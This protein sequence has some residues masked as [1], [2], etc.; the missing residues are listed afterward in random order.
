MKIHFGHCIGCDQPIRPP[1]RS[2]TVAVATGD[3]N[4]I[5][6]WESADVCDDCAAVMTVDELHGL[7]T[8]PEEAAA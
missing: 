5:D 2:F 4:S 3:G 8:A 7:V 6:E 1:F